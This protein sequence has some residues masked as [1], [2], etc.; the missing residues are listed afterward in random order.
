MTD[1]FPFIRTIEVDLS[2]LVLGEIFKVN[3]AKQWVTSNINTPLSTTTRVVW[4]I[5]ISPSLMLQREWNEVLKSFRH[6]SVLVLE[7]SFRSSP[8]RRRHPS[9][10]RSRCA[11]QLFLGR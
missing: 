8:C 11:P 9:L 5:L 7:V 3:D 4:V 2:C 6:Q 1:E 10:P